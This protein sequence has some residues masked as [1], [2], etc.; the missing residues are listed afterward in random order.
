MLYLYIYIYIYIYLYLYFISPY[1][2]SMY[3]LHSL[4]TP[5]CF[6]LLSPTILTR[7]CIFSALLFALFVCACALFSKPSLRQFRVGGGMS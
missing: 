2:L 5:S 7:S 3:R 6:L 4:Y 1:L